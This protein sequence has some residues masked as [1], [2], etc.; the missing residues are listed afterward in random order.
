MTGHWLTLPPASTLFQIF[1]HELKYIL[2]SLKR[3]YC[4]KNVIEVYD[5]KFSMYMNVDYNYN[6]VQQ[7]YT[8]K[9]KFYDCWLITTHSSLGPAPSNHCSSL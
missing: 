8:S 2:L 9:L 7:Y 6:V 3:F 5:L 1:F 4:D